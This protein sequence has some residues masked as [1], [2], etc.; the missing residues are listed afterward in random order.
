MREL[1]RRSICG[2]WKGSPLSES[3]EE[4]KALYTPPKQQQGFKLYD[5]R[6]NTLKNSLMLNTLMPNFAHNHNNNNSP[7]F[8]S[9]NIPE[10]LSPGLLDFPSL[11]LSPVTQF[12]D[13]PFDKSS[14]SLGNSSEE[15]KPIAERA[16]T[17]IP[18]P[19]LIQETQ[20]HSSCLFS[21]LLT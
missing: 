15:D 4:G 8:S 16:S 9:S 5:R 3:K 12:N 14:P 2:E 6:N 19:S 13:D 10:I 11:A 7:S 1:S 20:N 17:C 21:Q 18:L